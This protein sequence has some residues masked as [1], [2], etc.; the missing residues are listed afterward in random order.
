MNLARLAADALA[1]E[2]HWMRR[3][4]VCCNALQQVPA[5]IGQLSRLCVLNVSNNELRELPSEIASIVSLQ[6]LYADGNRLERIPPEFGA[7]G[8]LRILSLNAN[9]LAGLPPELG[10]LS[11]LV[12]LHLNDN[13]IAAIP[14]E[15]CRI[16]SLRTVQLHRNPLM[17]NLRPVNVDRI[18]SL[19]ELSARALCRFLRSGACHQR[20]P[21]KVQRLLDTAR[22]CSVCAGPFFQLE[23]RR[24]RIYSQWEGGPV[25]IVY[26]LCAPHEEE[27]LAQVAALL[28]AAGAVVPTSITG[29]LKA[30]RLLASR[31]DADHARRGSMPGLSRLR[32][33]PPAGR[34]PKSR[35]NRNSTHY[36]SLDRQ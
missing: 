14:A 5:A 25:P 16:H 23:M 36:E 29:P 9:E 1:E 4:I 11:S 13:S 15:M 2:A 10:R 19:R 35:E 26:S 18:P 6:E 17:P 34:A 33:W 32:S 12:E 27:E 31:D 28:A 8:K 3:L 21:P 22:T 20:I 24:Y 7:L 30:A